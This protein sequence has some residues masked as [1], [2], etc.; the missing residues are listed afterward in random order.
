M[1]HV[2]LLLQLR[3]T[4]GPSTFVIVHK[5]SDSFGDQLCLCVRSAAMTFAFLDEENDVVVGAVDDAQVYR[6]VFGL[7]VH[8]QGEMSSGTR[9]STAANVAAK[10]P[11]Q[12][13]CKI[14][15]NRLFRT[16]TGRMNHSGVEKMDEH[17]I[18]LVHHVNRFL[19]VENFCGNLCLWKRMDAEKRSYILRSNVDIVCIQFGSCPFIGMLG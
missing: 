16:G 7:M 1:G 11:Q 10:V 13:D 18:I 6:C 3:Q 14:D 9:I 2:Y 5:R 8:I 12:L 4:A 15:Y 17:R 19:H